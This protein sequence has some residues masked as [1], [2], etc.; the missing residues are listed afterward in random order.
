[1]SSGTDKSYDPALEERMQQKYGPDPVLEAREEE[2]R[3]STQK[4]S[5]EYFHETLGRA[6]KIVQGV[7]RDKYSGTIVQTYVPIASPNFEEGVFMAK[8][9]LM[10]Y[11]LQQW[12]GKPIVIEGNK[13]PVEQKMEIEEKRWKFTLTEDHW[14]EVFHA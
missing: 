10:V 9:L 13:K 1:M 6:T 7:G 2:K 8:K 14:C 11:F 4:M 3:K 12:Y 5:E